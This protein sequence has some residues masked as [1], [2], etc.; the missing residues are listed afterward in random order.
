MQAY[1]LIPLGRV[2]GISRDR[3]GSSCLAVTN[4]LARLQIRPGHAERPIIL[5]PRCMAPDA[6]EAVRETAKA[7]DCPVL[8][9]ETNEQARQTMREA[10][11]TCVITAAC[12]RDL[13]GGLF[14]Y[15]A[16]LPILAIANRRPDGPCFGT[17]ID[18]GELKEALAAALG[19]PKD[20]KG[21]H[22]D[23]TR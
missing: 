18:I 16:K 3:I 5:L 9:M 11:P 1:W 22:D 19:P 13:I 23:S 14:D 8:V 7:W 20:R 17:H 10:N 21:Q 2:V 12:E 15:G 6:V 4:A